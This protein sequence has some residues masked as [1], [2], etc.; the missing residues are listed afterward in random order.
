MKLDIKKLKEM[1]IPEEVAE[2]MT[3]HGTNHQM[4]IRSWNEPATAVYGSDT[5]IVALCLAHE[6]QKPDPKKAVVKR[7]RGRFSKLRHKEESFDFDCYLNPGMGF[8]K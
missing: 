5:N 6:I 7:L 4:L 2:Y 1:A 8:L 3:A